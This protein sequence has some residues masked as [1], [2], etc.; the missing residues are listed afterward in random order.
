MTKKCIEF[1]KKEFEEFKSRMFRCFRF[2]QYSMFIIEFV[3]ELIIIF[4]LIRSFKYDIIFIM[5]I[6]MMVVL[7]FLTCYLLKKRGGKDYS[8]RA[9]SDN[10]PE[11]SLINVIK[12]L[13]VIIGLTLLLIIIYSIIFNYIEG[14]NILL[15]VFSIIYLMELVLTGYKVS[16]FSLAALMGLPILFASQ[17]G[18]KEGLLTWGFLSF[19]LISFGMNFFDVS[20]VRDTLGLATDSKIDNDALERKV[21]YLFGILFLFFDLLLSEAFTSLYSYRL[22]ILNSELSEWFLYAAIKVLGLCILF[23]IYDYSWKRLTFL[24]INLIFKNKIKPVDGYYREVKLVK[25]KGKEYHWEISNHIYKLKKSGN[26]LEIISINTPQKCK[27]LYSDIKRASKDVL[28]VN[29]N[30]FIRKESKDLLKIKGSVKEYGYKLLN[31]PLHALSGLFIVIFIF[32]I[33]GLGVNYFIDTN[34]GINGNYVNVNQD[35]STP[36]FSKELH[37]ENYRVIFDDNIKIIDKELFTF[38]DGRYTIQVHKNGLLISDKVT[39]QKD[40]YMRENTSYYNK[41]VLQSE[42]S[43]ENKVEEAIRRQKQNSHN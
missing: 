7:V 28:K 26:N 19:I 5:A 13:G 24:F 21:Y 34:Y 16:P 8:L 22:L 35:T 15:T 23:P 42:I 33:L 20:L 18:I 25:L 37:I 43:Y 41:I 3:V 10:S 2:P 38:S 11:F 40:F 4:E 32:V 14:N 29:K 31:M 39:N 1:S 36:N 9:L 17:I 6:V 30:I 27:P 12:F